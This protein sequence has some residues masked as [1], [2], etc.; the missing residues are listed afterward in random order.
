PGGDRH[1][2]RGLRPRPPF[3][4]RDQT[5]RPP[6]ASPPADGRPPPSGSCR[7]RAFHTPPSPNSP[8]SRPTAAAAPLTSRRGYSGVDWSL[9]GLSGRVTLVTGANHGIGAA[10]AAVLAGQGAAVLLAYWRLHDEPDPAVPGAYAEGR[11]QPADDT[12]A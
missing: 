11:A 6:G 8:A 9:P 4:L 7:L 12:V 1:G 5:S 10:T 3:G 2:R